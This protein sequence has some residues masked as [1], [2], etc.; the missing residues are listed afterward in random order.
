MKYV[1]TI[2]IGL[3]ILIGV[4]FFLFNVVHKAPQ[5]SPPPGSFTGSINTT[6]SS[7][8]NPTGSQTNT[9]QNVPQATL[10]I[11]DYSGTPVLVRD[12]LHNSNTTQDPV[13]QGYY[14]IGAT[15]SD[16][17]AS[18][19]ISY[20]NDTQFFGIALLREPL[21]TS[22]QEAEQYLMQQLGISQDEMCKLNYTMSVS[23]DV[24]QYY[25]GD[26]FGF[27]FCPGAMPLP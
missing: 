2:S 11:K 10:M 17:T 12:F 16:T 14:H 5:P 22:R 19:A 27:S 7:G 15:A 18:F 9:Q 6:Q 20:I 23:N 25:A 4:A 24:N 21:S 26:S 3:L 1:I 13:N 8:T